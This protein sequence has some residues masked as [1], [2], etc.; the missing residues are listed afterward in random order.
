M[1]IFFILWFKNMLLTMSAGDCVTGDCVTGDCVTGDCVTGDCVN[2][3]CVT[4]DC[5]TWENVIIKC[6]MI[7]YNFI[8]FLIKAN[9]S[10][11]AVIRT[12]VRTYVSNAYKTNCMLNLSFHFHLYEQRTRVS[13]YE[14]VL[15]MLW[16]Q[17]VNY[18]VLFTDRYEL[19]K[20][21]FP[22]WRTGFCIS[23]VGKL[24]AFERY[25]S[26]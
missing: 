25:L 12:S 7:Q 2:G 26:N 24:L 10:N 9:T 17:F 6:S 13:Q 5:V 20:N 3:D 14:L 21:R 23:D 4:G 1:S 11:C 16:K 22:H 15:S 18:V 8:L 19:S